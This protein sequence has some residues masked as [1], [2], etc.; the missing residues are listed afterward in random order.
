MKRNTARTLIVLA[1]FVALIV[2]LISPKVQRRSS[3]TARRNPM[4]MPR[5]RRPPLKTCGSWTAIARRCS[6]D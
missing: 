3:R 4:V 1:S 5:V 6:G 2:T